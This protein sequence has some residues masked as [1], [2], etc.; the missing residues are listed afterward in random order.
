LLCMRFICFL[1][2]TLCSLSGVRTFAQ[3]AK[4]AYGY[5]GKSTY[6]KTRHNYNVTRV[7]GEKAKIVC[8]IFSASKYP[9]Q[10]FG[11]KFGDPFAFTYKFY[12]SKKF[13][14]VLDLGKPASALYNRYYREKFDSYIITDTF[15]TAEASIVAITHKV[16]SDIIMEA[17]LLYHVDV[18]KISPG[19]QLYVGG[20]FEWKRTRLQYDYTY[21][22]GGFRDLDEFGRFERSRFTMGPQIVMGIEYSYFSIPI[23]AFMELEYFSDILADPGWAKLEGGVGLRYIF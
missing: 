22:S 18:T 3:R 10:G 23:S 15:K 7:R 14:V 9:Y 1:I 13:A 11:F 20:G 16:K 21:S 12:A 6:T 4:S 2:L 8:P 19:L 17:K 5:G